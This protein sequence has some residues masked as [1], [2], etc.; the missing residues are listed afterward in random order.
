MSN[1][2]GIDASLLGLM[3]ELRE[4][5][6]RLKRL[7]AEAQLKADMVAEALAET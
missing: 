1:F 4:D 7:C 3:K 5:A 2:G 6:R